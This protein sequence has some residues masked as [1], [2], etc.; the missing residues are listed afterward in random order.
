MYEL[1]PFWYVAVALLVGEWFGIWLLL[2]LLELREAQDWR[3]QMRK[4][5]PPWK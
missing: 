5:G 3:G 1:V 2:G 4:Y